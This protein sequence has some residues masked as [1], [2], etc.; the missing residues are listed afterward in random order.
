MRLSRCRIKRALG[1]AS[2]PSVLSRR[3]EALFIRPSSRCRWKVCRLQLNEQLRH[4]G[5]AGGGS[6]TL[7]LSLGKHES[8]QSRC[9]SFGLELDHHWPPQERRSAPNTCRKGVRVVHNHLRNI[10]EPYSDRDCQKGQSQ[11]KRDINY[12]LDSCLYPQAAWA[13]KVAR[14]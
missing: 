5:S 6:R 4:K 10:I 3:V 9:L 13:T 7:S 1:R 8:P 2:W 11:P 14:T 12:R